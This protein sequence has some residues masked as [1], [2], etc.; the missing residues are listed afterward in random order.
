VG[1]VLGDQLVEEGGVDV[2]VCVSGRC[3]GVRAHDEVV[4]YVGVPAAQI[5]GRL[6]G[7]SSVQGI[8]SW[9]LVAKQDRI[10]PP[11]AERVM[12]ARAHAETVSVNSSH[13]AMMSHPG[14][15]ARLI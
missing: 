2:G 15:V 3:A 4:G 1:H 11:E 14:V 7:L 6:N 8:L 12:A 5:V 9:Y 10:I 13:V